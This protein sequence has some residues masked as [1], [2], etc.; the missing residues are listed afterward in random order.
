MRYRRGDELVLKIEEDFGYSDKTYR[1][2]KVQVIGFNV[3]ADGDE[4]EYLVYVPPY[5]HLKDTW[6]LT[7]RHAEWYGAHPKFVGDD[8]AFI[9]ARHPIYK[10]IPAL[11]GES[12][13]KCGDFSAGAVRPSADEAY[14][15]R[16]CKL[17]PFR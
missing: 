16:S 12:C 4:A 13:D 7:Q 5:E 2:V 8:V 1:Q 15:C 17:N 11:E 10:H 3:D 6:T 14:R 9:V